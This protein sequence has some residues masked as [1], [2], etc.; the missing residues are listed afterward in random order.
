[1]V[2]AKHS[3]WGEALAALA[4]AEAIDPNF[5]MTYVYRGGVLESTGDKAGAAIQYQ[6]ALTLN[7]SN[8]IARDALARVSH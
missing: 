4:R 1:M 6:R 7:P 5:D 2:Y 3:K 8:S